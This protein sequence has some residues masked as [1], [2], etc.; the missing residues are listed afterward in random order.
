MG[1]HV[2]VQRLQEN[3]GLWLQR[4]DVNLDVVVRS[5]A[6]NSREADIEVFKDGEVLEGLSFDFRDG[7]YHISRKDGYTRV[8]SGLKI[9]VV[10]RRTNPEGTI[11]LLFSH[12][13]SYK[14]GPMQYPVPGTNQRVRPTLVHQP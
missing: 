5:V 12:K 13:R 3:S 1:K 9:R 11:P 8:D 6:P 10:A 14:L 2:F 7:L 4:R